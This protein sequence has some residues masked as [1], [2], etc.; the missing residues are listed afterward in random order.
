MA[1]I[2]NEFVH[3]YAHSERR[4]ITKKKKTSNGK[5]RIQIAKR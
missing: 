5:R 1:S 4:K 2:L 3:T